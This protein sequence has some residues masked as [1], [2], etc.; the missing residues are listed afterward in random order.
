MYYSL[1]TMQVSPKTSLYQMQ[2]ELQQPTVQ[3]LRYLLVIAIGKLISLPSKFVRTGQPKAKQT[4]IS[5]QYNVQQTE[6]SGKQLVLLM[7]QE[8]AVQQKAMLL[9]MKN[10]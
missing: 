4:V 7:P 8:I 3:S 10:Q 5:S 1:P 6:Q 2:E 9:Q